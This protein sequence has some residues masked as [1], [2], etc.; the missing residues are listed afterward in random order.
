MGV[1]GIRHGV[2]PLLRWGG[3]GVMDLQQPKVEGGWGE[4]GR[5]K[6][7]DYGLNLGGFLVIT[8]GNMISF[9]K[10]LGLFLFFTVHSLQNI[11]LST[12]EIKY[13]WNLMFGALF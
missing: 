11:C 5:W 6:N 1:Y 3:K 8:C 10:V 12:V 2:S 4:K 7:I 13:W 9:L